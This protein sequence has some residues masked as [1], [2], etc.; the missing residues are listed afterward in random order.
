MT[1]FALVAPVL[2]LMFFGI[3]DFGRVIYIYGTLVQAAQE[4]ARTS[5]RA[6]TPLP[7]D[8]DVVN[9]AKAHASSLRLANPCPNGPL[10]PTTGGLAQNPP[11]GTGWIF[12]TEPNPPTT[13]ESA[14]TYDAPGGETPVPATSSCSA[15]N[16]YISGTY[17]L[18][19]TIRFN[20]PFFTPL[21]E[22]LAPNIILQAYATEYTEY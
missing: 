3:I 12:I 2:L 15:V 8:D 17:P 22:Q 16:S 20:Y 11:S 14:P 10:P 18:Q 21:L 13:V 7:T 4:G 1:E 9:T 6:S 19:V 5:V